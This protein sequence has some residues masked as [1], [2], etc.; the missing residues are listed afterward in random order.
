MDIIYKTAIS[1][2]EGNE[3]LSDAK[4]YINKEY[5]LCQLLSG[6]PEDA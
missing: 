3:S 5:N 2:Y 6:T 4:K 1:V